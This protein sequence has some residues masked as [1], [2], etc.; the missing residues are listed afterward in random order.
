MAE[1]QAEFPSIA[2]LPELFDLWQD[3]IGW[4]PDP[5]QQSLFQQLY[6]LILQGNRQLNLTRITDP[7]DFWEKHLWDSLRGI[8]RFLLETQPS[9]PEIPEAKPR[10]PLTVIDIG[11]GAGFPGVPVAIACPSWTVTLLDSTRKKLQ[12]LDRVLA[13]LRI[14]GA[15]TLLDR[16]EQ[17]GHLPNQRQQYDLALIRAVAAAPICA[18]Y[19]LPLLKRDGYAV[20]YRGLWSNVEE[21]E[22]KA[23][24]KQLGG[25]IEAIEAFQTPL[26]SSERHCIYLKKVAATPEQFPRPIGV[27][28]Q[29]PLG[30]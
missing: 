21:V 14:D 1:D 2:Q 24:V 17:A 4:Q 30:N 18:E 5:F 11:T 25:K 6:A 10:S 26:T 13:E 20:L 8:K 9:A 7:D 16:A 27:P 15:V 28:T 22:L 19:A 12:F 3:T 23:A 29:Q